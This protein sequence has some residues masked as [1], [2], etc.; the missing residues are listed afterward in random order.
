M[1]KAHK[2]RCI[3]LSYCNN[4]Y[5]SLHDRFS[6]S[7]QHEI[8]RWLRWYNW[9]GLLSNVIY[10]IP[11]NGDQTLGKKSL[12]KR[13]STQYKY[14]LKPIHIKNVPI[15]LR[16]KVLSPIILYIYEI[17]VK[18]LFSKISSSHSWKYW[19]KLIYNEL[20]SQGILCK[21]CCV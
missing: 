13:A 20:A 8:R 19:I 14:L 6:F 11:S 7:S 3:Q 16:F 12:L 4:Q 17:F 21:N 5:V 2:N 15:V 9:P 10:Y 18:K 1:A